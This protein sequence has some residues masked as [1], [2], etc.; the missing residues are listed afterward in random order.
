MISVRSVVQLYPG[1]LADV[2][3]VASNNNSL[4][5]VPH[6][7]ANTPSNS[8]SNKP[9]RHKHAGSYLFSR[10]TY[11]EAQA[12]SD[13]SEVRQVLRRLPGPG[14]QVGGAD[15]ERREARHAG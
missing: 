10:R 3:V 7:A 1:P 9:A 4:R 8:P 14:R 2:V 11:G 6:P 5:R 15:P 12:Q 13:L